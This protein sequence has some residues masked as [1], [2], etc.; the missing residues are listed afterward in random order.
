M[1]TVY[2]EPDEA[3]GFSENWHLVLL[4]EITFVRKHVGDVS[5]MFLLIKTVKLVGVIY[6]MF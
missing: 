1:D 4:Q 6:C 3:I 5:L 2:N